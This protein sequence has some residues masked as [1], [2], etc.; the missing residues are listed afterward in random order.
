MK[1]IKL[2]KD[3][4]LG[5]SDAED[6]AVT[7]DRLLDAPARLVVELKLGRNAVLKR[8]KA[9]VPITV[10]CLAGSG[11]FNA[12]EELEDSQELKTGTFITLEAGVYHEVTAAEGLHLIVSKF[13]SDN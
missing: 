11:Q 12:G 13:R 7:V 6:S 8:H 1:N 2:I 3:L 10:L 5:L 4:E 9:D